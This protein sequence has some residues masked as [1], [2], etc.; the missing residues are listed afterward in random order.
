MTV[1][2]TVPDIHNPSTVVVSPDQNYIYAG[3]EDHDFRQRGYGGGLTAFRFD[4]TTGQ[5]EKINDS[6]AYGSS[7][8]YITLDKT[9]K[10]IFVAN[11]GSKYYCTRYPR[12]GG[13]ASAAG[14]PGRGM[15]LR[16]CRSGGRRNR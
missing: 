7:T 11:H 9:G 5:A 10:F 14:H 4:M 16:V 12:C 1:H 8:A 3:N 6:L 15:H 2:S 13:K